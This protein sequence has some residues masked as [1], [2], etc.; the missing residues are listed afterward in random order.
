M[1][2]TFDTFTITPDGGHWLVYGDVRGRT[3]KY[4][5]I[6]RHR[7]QFVAARMLEPC[8]PWPTTTPTK[9]GD[10]YQTLDRAARALVKYHH[11]REGTDMPLFDNTKETEVSS[12][13]SVQ[14]IY[15]A[16]VTV[17]IAPDGTMTSDVLIA[18]DGPQVNDAEGRTVS[19]VVL[20]DA[21]IKIADSA[22]GS[23]AH[24]LTLEE[25]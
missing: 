21:V 10:T 25:K 16:H 1:A 2:V 12:M 3:I 18:N 23:D 5:T 20:R 13:P 14:V 24:P 8:E 22:L 4:G 6:S 17:N 15:D 7:D 19:S 11:H 9:V